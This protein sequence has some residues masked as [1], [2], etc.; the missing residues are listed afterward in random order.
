[1]HEIIRTD[2]TVL[3]PLAESDADD[4]ARLANQW[5]ICRMT[6]SFPY[7]FDAMSVAGRVEIYLARAATGTAIHWAVTV[8]GE[9]IGAIGLYRTDE[10][11]DMGYWIGEPWWG[12]GFASEVVTAVTHHVFQHHPASA[13][14][15]CVFTDNPASA[16]V[17]RKVGFRQSE[18]VCKGYSLARRG[19][20]DNWTFACTPTDVA[21]RQDPATLQTAH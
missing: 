9:F 12:R 17:L 7:P 19:A 11:W 18:T 3:R 15:A 1:M 2:R 10:G 20:M 16:H 14:S 21:A 5:D 6:G 13:L 4:F 8:R